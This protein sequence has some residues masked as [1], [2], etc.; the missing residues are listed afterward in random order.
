MTR[1]LPRLLFAVLALT[2]VLS[3]ASAQVPVQAPDRAGRPLMLAPLPRTTEAPKP[4]AAEMPAAESPSSGE[5]QVQSL[6]AIDVDSVG[7]LSAAEGGLGEA[8]WRGTPR[9]LLEGCCPPSHRRRFGRCRAGRAVFFCR[10]GAAA[11]RR[12]Q[13]GHLLATRADLSSHGRL[14]GG[15]T[16]SW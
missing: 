7:T 4:A 16:P 3:V 9:T 10:R 11:G 14:R 8:M 5:V 12:R 1:T 15:S 6:Q 13:K 2:A